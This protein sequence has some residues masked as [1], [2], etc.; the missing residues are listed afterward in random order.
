[1]VYFVYSQEYSRYDFGKSHPLR[2]ERYYLTYL[3]AKEYGLFSK[4]DLVEPEIFSEEVLQLVHSRE[5]IDYVKEM[6][7]REEGY[8]D[9]GDTPAFKGC[10]EASFLHVRGTLTAVKKAIE[11]GEPAVNI[12]GGYHHAKRSS[13]GGFCIFN[14][15]ALAVK[16][17]EERGYRKIAV[18]DTDAHHGD[19][20][21]EILY[22][23]DVL[24]IDIH[25]SGEYLYPG[26]GFEN[27]LGVGDGYGYMV[28]IPLL[29]YSGDTVFLKAVYELVIPL[30]K[31]YRPQIIIHQLGVDTYR[32]DP[33]TH[34]ALSIRAYEKL[35]SVLISVLSEISSKYVVV[36]GGG[37][38]LYAVPRVY[39]MISAALAETKLSKEIPLKWI[40][41]YEKKIGERAPRFLYEEAT[42]GREPAKGF[43]E[44]HV[45][46][47]I[48]RLKKR[49]SDIHGNIF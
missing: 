21:Q 17:L 4:L 15:I 29:P 31:W 2:P 16:Y 32:G 20:T 39:V 14:D 22:S 19:G 42:W 35:V 46:A 1:M 40:K 49:L 44:K 7:R 43:P 13:A 28:N 6:S 9:Y 3:L 8:L 37:Y 36:G 30:I 11:T 26:T 10:F 38:L 5:Y 48:E 45:L 23:D 27:E 24:K 33:L 12:A 47:L 25:E 18:V 41:L 34:M